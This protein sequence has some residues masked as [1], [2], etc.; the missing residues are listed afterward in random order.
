MVVTWWIVT[1]C[2]VIMFKELLK[3]MHIAYSH[4]EKTMREVINNETWLTKSG[5]GIAS[6][7][8]K[9]MMTLQFIC[10][11]YI[12]THTTCKSVF[13]HLFRKLFR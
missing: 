5:Q 2:A 3:P 11:P 7:T 4:D 1:F 13:L 10:P 6:C 12:Y 8:L 9:I